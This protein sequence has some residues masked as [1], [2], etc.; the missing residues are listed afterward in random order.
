[1]YF[2]NIIFAAVSAGLI[3]GAVLAVLQHFFVTPVI[4]NAEQF[5]VVEPVNAGQLEQMAGHHHDDMSTQGEHTHNHSHEAWAPDDGFERSLA[6][7]VSTALA[8]IGF[9]LLLSS[10]MTFRSAPHSAVAQL[11]RGLFWG[12]SG[13]AVFFVAP[14]LGLPPEIPGA[15]ATLLNGR[16]GWWMM[17]VLFS[18]AGLALLFFI[19]SPLRFAGLFV[20]AVPHILGAPVPEHHGFSHPDPEAVAQLEVLAAQFIQNTGIVNG[21]FWIVLGIT[22]SMML[23]LF[24]EKESNRS[25]NE[26][27]A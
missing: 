7:F 1:M 19:R 22:S 2:R 14:A 15:E 4:L 5:E 25:N 24:L 17:T 10:G 26:G 18:A 16:Q 8:A 21:I 13:Y 3:S 27:F 20:L 12:A 11:K 23:N 9:G 6:T